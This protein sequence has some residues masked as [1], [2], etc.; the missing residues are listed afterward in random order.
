MDEHLREQLESIPSLASFLQEPEGEEEQVQTGTLAGRIRDLLAQVSHSPRWYKAGMLPYTL[1]KDSA[2][3]FVVAVPMPETD[4]L[5][6]KVVVEDETGG[7]HVAADL[8]P[9]D[10]MLAGLARTS[11]EMGGTQQHIADLSACFSRIIPA[12]LEASNLLASST[13]I[14]EQR[15]KWLRYEIAHACK[16]LSLYLEELKGA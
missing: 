15:K 8:P 7:L 2:T 6:I 9:A 10:D 5:S 13:A 3:V 14:S 12:L 11:E 1:P 16:H 4:A